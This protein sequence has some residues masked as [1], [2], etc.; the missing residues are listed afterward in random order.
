MV[1]IRRN[2]PLSPGIAVGK[3]GSRPVPFFSRCIE[4]PRHRFLRRV[5]S[6][7]R[8][9]HRPPIG[10]LCRCLTKRPFLETPWGRAPGGPFFAAPLR[11]SHTS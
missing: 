11:Y 2:G 10:G 1:F 4:Y 9:A 3:T 5:N 6:T 7:P 8:A